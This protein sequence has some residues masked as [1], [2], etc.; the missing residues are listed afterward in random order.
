MK[1]GAAVTAIGFAKKA[2]RSSNAKESSH[3]KARGHRKR[4]PTSQEDKRSYYKNKNKKA[5][6]N[7]ER[8]RSLIPTKYVYPDPNVPRSKRTHSLTC[9]CD[10]CMCACRPISKVLKHTLSFVR[11]YLMGPRKAC[12]RRDPPCRP[13]QAVP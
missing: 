3:A 9:S 8:L 13:L 5:A 6:T 2:S 12:H 7:D 11:A 10:A 1:L 4:A